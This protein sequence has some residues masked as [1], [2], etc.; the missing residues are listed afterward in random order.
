MNQ[1]IELATIPTLIEQA[2]ENGRLSEEC[3]IGAN[4]LCLI[5]QECIFVMDRLN[6]H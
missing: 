6:K 5:N 2:L 4:A 3:Y 1:T